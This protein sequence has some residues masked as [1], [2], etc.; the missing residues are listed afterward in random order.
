[1]MGPKDAVKSRSRL[2]FVETRESDN[3]N[4]HPLEF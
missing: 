3:W 4:A 2:V 1:M